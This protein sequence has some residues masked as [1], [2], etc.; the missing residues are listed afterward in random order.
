MPT[1]ANEG[2]NRAASS[3]KG[4]RVL[5]VEDSWFVA[6]TLKAALEVMGMTVARPAATVADAERLLAEN[7]FDLAVMDINLKGEMTYD[8]IDRLHGQGVRVVVLSGYPSMSHS[9]ESASAILEKPVSGKELL[10]T[11]R[12]VMHSTSDRA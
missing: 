1:D 11:L 12:Q 4:L 5:V 2:P 10:I 8:L 7:A 3:L 9:V 6:K